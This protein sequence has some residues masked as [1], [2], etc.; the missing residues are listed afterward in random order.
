MCGQRF[1]LGIPYAKCDDFALFL[2][3]LSMS[4]RVDKESK[5]VSV[6]NLWQLHLCVL[7][8]ALGKRLQTLASERDWVEE[9]SKRSSQGEGRTGRGVRQT[10][11]LWEGG[12]V[13]PRLLLPT[14]PAVNITK[15]IRL[16]LGGS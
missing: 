11:V 6:G 14:A 16:T 13:S 10:L 12:G 3:M 7:L 2:L 1:S 9:S 4:S 15:V 8:W 5:G